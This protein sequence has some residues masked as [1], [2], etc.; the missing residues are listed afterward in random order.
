MQRQCVHSFVS[1]A[2]CFCL[3]LRAFLDYLGHRAELLGI[4][5]AEGLLGIG[6]MGDGGCSGRLLLSGLIK[7]DFG[8]VSG[9]IQRTQYTVMNTIKYSLFV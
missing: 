2:S 8:T 4:H 6:P 3:G 1:L 5:G 9:F 7:A